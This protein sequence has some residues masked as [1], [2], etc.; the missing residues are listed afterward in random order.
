[1][2]GWTLSSQ[3]TGRPANVCKDGCG[4]RASSD[5]SEVIVRHVHS[6]LALVVLACAGEI[7]A[8]QRAATAGSPA[9]L[10]ADLL[11]SSD[12][13]IVTIQNNRDVSMEAW[14]F[15]VTCQRASK[16]NTT[17][18]VTTDAYRALALPLSRPDGPIAPGEKRA[19]NLGP[20][21]DAVVKGTTLLL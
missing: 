18:E 4:W 11:P 10:S 6:P 1:M 16:R 12:D 13:L 15:E 9:R 20:H 17:D 21:H 7:A 5:A 2:P 8:A 3:L 14:S 19:V